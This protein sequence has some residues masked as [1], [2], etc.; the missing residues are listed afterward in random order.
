MSSEARHARVLIVDDV[1]INCMI[2]SSLLASGGVESDI[3]GGG[4]ECLKLCQEKEYDLILLDHR[5]PDIDGVDTLLKLKE[6]FRRTGREVPVVCHTTE[7]ARRNINLY[8]AAG[9]ADVLIKPIGPGEISEVISTYLSEDPELRRKKDEEKRQELQQKAE[10]LP[11]FL[12]RVE[13]I[14]PLAGIEYCETAG[15]YLGALKVF[16]SSIPEK[17]R[18]IEDF[19]NSSN[20]SM[21][22]L[23][24]HSLKSIARLVGAGKLSDMAAGLEYAAKQGQ[25]DTLKSLTP[26]LLAQYRAFDQSLAPL[27]GEKTE[28]PPRAETVSLPPISRSVLEEAFSAIS[29]CARLYDGDNI[30]MILNSLRDYALEEET[31]EKMR[32][33][34]YA[35]KHADWETI[36]KVLE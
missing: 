35:L 5:M 28:Q 21:Y 9:F 24:V 36:R 25:F 1:P 17:A 3:A 2:L 11:D 27:R 30:L 31:A 14:D 20:F 29:D 23:R 22:A 10:E 19:Y 16:A 32:R 12:L 4:Q 33:I 18:E 34:E 6:H 13:G 7:D 15:D 8:K 26:S